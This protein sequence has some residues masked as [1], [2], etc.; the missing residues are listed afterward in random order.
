MFVNRNT[1]FG[2]FKPIFASPEVQDVD[3]SLSTFDMMC[4]NFGGVPCSQP[5][6][7]FVLCEKNSV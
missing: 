6:K 5:E 1:I 4:T 7:A 3:K 2:L